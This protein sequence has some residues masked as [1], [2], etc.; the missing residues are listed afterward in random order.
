MED[1][2]AYLDLIEQRL[3]MGFTAIKFHC[4]CQPEKDLKLCRA[5]RKAFPDTAFMH[6]V[7]NNYSQEAALRVAQELTSL[8]FTWF[9]APF[10]DYDLES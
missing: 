6:D 5:A 4:W 3:D 7:E 9:E 2:P 10:P 8:D 1:V